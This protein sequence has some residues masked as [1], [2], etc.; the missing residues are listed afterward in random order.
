MSTIEILLLTSSALFAWSMGSHYTGSVAGTVYGAGV[1]SLR[2]ALVLTAVFTLIGSVLGSINVVDTYVNVVSGASDVDIAAA[3]LS[4]AVVTTG[5]TYFK[6]PTSTIQIYAFSLLGVA[7]VAGLPVSAAA[8]GLLVVGWVAGP[9]VAFVLGLVF[10]RLGMGIAEKGERALRLFLIV[11]VI[12]SAFILGSN[13][14]SNAASSLVAADLF[15]PR[16]A[17]L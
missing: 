16:L 15:S 13:D 3:Q 14:V 12:Y 5:C 17:A 11:V 1:F 4:A 8:F 10:A 9:L 7:L 6:V 2:T